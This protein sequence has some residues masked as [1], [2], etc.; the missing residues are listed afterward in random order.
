MPV[1]EPTPEE[2][3]ALIGSEQCAAWQK[4]CEGIDSLYEMEHQWNSGGKKWRY[5][6]KFR[7]GQKTL[8]ALYAAQDRCGIMMIFGAAEREKTAEVL[9]TL[10]PLL[11]KAYEE[12]TVY[13]DGKWVMFPL[14]QEYVQDYICLLACKRRPN[15]VPG[16]A[17]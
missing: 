3:A 7:R 4:V 2:L 8:C 9:P 16:S 14:G 13:H 10:S 1:N 12:A 15:R 17:E 11:Q 5:E 6:Y